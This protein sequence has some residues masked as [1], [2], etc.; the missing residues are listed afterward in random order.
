MSYNSALVKRIEEAFE[1]ELPPKAILKPEF[2]SIQEA[3]DIVEHLI[4]RRWR[5]VDIENNSWLL[6]QVVW[7][8]KEAFLYYMPAF[9]VATVKDGEIENLCFLAQFT[10]HVAR[11]EG[12]SV[13]LF[14]Q[15]L[16]P[17][18]FAAVAQVIRYLVD[19]DFCGD[20]SAGELA[21]YFLPTESTDETLEP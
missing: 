20:G 9:L 7:F 11:R 13:P 17:K 10:R 19:S 8:T 12:L 1:S 18:Q 21:A 3:A 2:E 15:S 4:G 6:W 5:D 14:F 16:T